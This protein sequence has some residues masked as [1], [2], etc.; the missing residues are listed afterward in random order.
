MGAHGRCWHKVGLKIM[1]NPPLALMKGQTIN[2]LLSSAQSVTENP[3]LKTFSGPLQGLAE[4][5]VGLSSG[6]PSSPSLHPSEGGCHC[7]LQEEKPLSLALP[8]H[9]TQAG[10]LLSFLAIPNFSCA[11]FPPGSC[12]HN[13]S[14]VVALGGCSEVHIQ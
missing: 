14:A 8:K 6:L 2:I 4:A 10:A 1:E 13:S 12:C 5:E 3:S 11:T 9:L 7:F